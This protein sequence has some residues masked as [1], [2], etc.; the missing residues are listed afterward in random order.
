MTVSLLSFAVAAVDVCAPGRFGRTDS[1]GLTIV[2]EVI[3]GV[4]ACCIYT[5]V[6]PRFIPRF[7]QVCLP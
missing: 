1:T 3:L 6:L 5:V 2:A 4:G 7:T